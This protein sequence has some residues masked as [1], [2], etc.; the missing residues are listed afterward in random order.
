MGG[1]RPRP[2]LRHLPRP[3]LGPRLPTGHPAQAHRRAGRLPALDLRQ[4][5]LGREPLGATER[6]ARD[7]NPLR[8]NRQV[9]PRRPLLRRHLR[10][11]QGLTGLSPLYALKEAA[12]AAGAGAA[13]TPEAILGV[14]SLM[15]WAL[16][17]VVSLKYAILI[18]R[19]DN[20]GEGGIMAMLA[21][22]H[23][24]D[25]PPS[26]SRALILVL[27]LIGAALLYGDGAITPAI[28]V[29]SAV[30]GLKVDAPQLAPLIMPITVAILMVLFFIQWKG[31]TFIGRIFGPV[32][33]VWFTVLSILGLVEIARA[34]GVLAAANPV[35]AFN[36]LLHAPLKVSFAV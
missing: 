14:L 12:K 4:P 16:I 36:F 33:L 15:L 28:S 25:A 35:Y 21:L 24:R 29:L 26:G 3:D 30:E 13:P 18:L 6:V 5:A 27:G 11:A 31:T 2:C 7:R 8:E 17:L 22:L 34:P 19:A 10:L 32:M 9:L 1:R 20:R 23:S